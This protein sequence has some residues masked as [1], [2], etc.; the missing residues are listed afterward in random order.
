M[1]DNETL[2]QNVPE[3]FIG[4]DRFEVRKKLLRF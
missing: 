1:N 4:L 2:N 3:E